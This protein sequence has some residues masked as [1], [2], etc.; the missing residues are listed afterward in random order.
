[1]VGQIMNNKTE[2]TTHKG[3]G[4]QGHTTYAYQS[5]DHFQQPVKVGDYKIY[6]TNRTGW[7]KHKEKWI[8]PDL[9]VALSDTWVGDFTIVY[10]NGVE[11]S[12]PEP[13]CPTIFIDWTDQKRCPDNV[14]YWLVDL[15][16]KRLEKRDMVEVSCMGAHGR[17]GTFLACLIGYVEGLEPKE[18]ILKLRARYCDEAVESRAQFEQVYEFLGSSIK[19][20]ETDWNFKP[21]FDWNKYIQK[22]GFKNKEGKQDTLDKKDDAID[23]VYG[24]DWWYW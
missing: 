11:E 5:C 6:V 13:V 12:L 14:L 3:T 22:F 20:V 21:P 2:D 19:D 9:F 10:A 18:A 16:S 15:V 8:P 23:A 24:Q 7:W 17:T 4:Y 1:M